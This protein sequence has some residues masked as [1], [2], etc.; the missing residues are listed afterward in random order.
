MALILLASADPAFASPNKEYSEQVPAKGMLAHYKF[1]AD[2]SDSC[3]VS[4]PFQL[5]NTKFVKDTLY[6]NGCYEHGGDFGYRAIANLPG[7]NYKSFTISLEFKPL[8]PSRRTNILTR[9]FNLSFEDTGNIITG[10]TSHRWFGIRRNRKGALEITLNNQDYVHTYESVYV[11]N[12]AWNR[13]TCCVDLENMLIRTFFNGK[14]LEDVHLP[15]DFVLSVLGSRSEDSDEQLTFT[16]YSNGKT[17]TG[18]VDN[19]RVFDCS[20][21]DE[22]VLALSFDHPLGQSAQPDMIVWTTLAICLVLLGLR[23]YRK[24]SKCQRR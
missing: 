17:F 22:D 1:D 10:G 19:L 18:Y 20:L 8:D 23:F 2:G 21:D 24:K 16:N 15:S 6:L 11:N 3:C 4:D 12:E 14:G 5:S 7:L 13:I 9:L